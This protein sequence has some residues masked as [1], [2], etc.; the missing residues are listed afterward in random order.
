MMGSKA[1]SRMAAGRA[2]RRMFAKTSAKF[3]RDRSFDGLTIDWQH[4][5]KRGG[6]PRDKVNY[7]LLLKVRSMQLFLVN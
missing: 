3:L 4:P 5:T 7:S 1:F 6:K 2:S